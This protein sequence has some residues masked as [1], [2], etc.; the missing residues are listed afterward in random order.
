[1]TTIPSLK[2]TGHV[3]YWE[4]HFILFL[5]QGNHLVKDDF[6]GCPELFAAGF[7]LF[8]RKDETMGPLVPQLDRVDEP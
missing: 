2:P 1:M 6:L 7:D 8:G 3:F 5:A 4:Q